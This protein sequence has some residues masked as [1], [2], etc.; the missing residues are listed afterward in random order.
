[1]YLH[2]GGDISI[3]NSDILG[4]FD[5]DN[6]TVE[7]TTRDY[8]TKAEK[9]GDVVNVSFELPKSF[10]VCRDKS[11]K[12]G[13]RVYISQIATSTLLKRSKHISGSVYS[14]PSE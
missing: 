5:L 11:R 4:V 12:S 9:D 13:R 8:L 3:K 7:K 10:I 2:L 1:M 14:R 6:A